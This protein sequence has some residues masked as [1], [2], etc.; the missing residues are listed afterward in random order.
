M[1][2]AWTHFTG[3]AVTAHTPGGG[4]SCPV[5]MQHSHQSVSQSV[6][7]WVRQSASLWL[8]SV[9]SGAGHAA[10]SNRLNGWHDVAGRSHYGCRVT[11]GDKASV[12][13]QYTNRSRIHTHTDTLF[14][15]Q[16]AGMQ[17]HTHTHTHRHTQCE[18]QYKKGYSFTVYQTDFHRKN[19]QPSYSRTQTLRTNK[20][21]KY[22]RG[23]REKYTTC[24][25]GKHTAGT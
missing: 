16:P 9:S 17:T 25:E 1:C 22:M 18:I 19:T 3:R 14:S 6:S 2:S 12:V 21:I 8:V 11:S 7:G 23:V 5:H 10:L 24:L 20:L 15:H 4:L 13:F